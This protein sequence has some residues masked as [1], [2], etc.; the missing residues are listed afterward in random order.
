MQNPGPRQLNLY[1]HELLLYLVSLIFYYMPRQI[2]RM[3]GDDG[4]VPRRSALGRG[5]GAGGGVWCGWRLNRD[6]M[7]G[8]RRRYMGSAVWFCREKIYQHVYYYLFSEFGETKWCA[9][10]HVYI[11]GE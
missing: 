7:P 5:G 4:A 11:L 3:Q 1:E 2:P 6:V 10:P 9:R 8:G